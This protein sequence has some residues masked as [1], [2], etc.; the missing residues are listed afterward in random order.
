M[1]VAAALAAA[2]VTNCG[3]HSGLPFLPA[4]P[5]APRT[6]HK[7]DVTTAYHDAVLAS[8]PIAYYRLDDTGSSA[9][10]I[11]PNHLNGAVG[12]SVVKS[13]AGLVPTAPDTAMSFPGLKTAAGSVIVPPNPL[14]QVQ[15]QL[16]VECF[17][18]FTTVPALW[19]VPVSYGNDNNYSPYALYF[20]TNGTLNAQF[21]LTSGVLI[22]TDPTPLQPNT[23]YYI[24]ATYD[25]TTGRLYVNGTQVGTATK[26]GA[27]TNY[28]NKYGLGIGD[29]SSFSDPGFAGTLDEVAIYGKTLSAADVTAHYNAAQTGTGP[30]PTPSPSP[31]PTP[32]ATP[33]PSP[34]PPSTSAYSNAVLNSGPVAYYRLDD[35]GPAV[36]DSSS[37]HLNG[38]AG[39]N[40][41]KNAAGLIAT[42]SDAAMSFPG[43]RT[44]ANI[45]SVAPNSLFQAPQVTIETFLK[46]NSTP[47]AYTVPVAYGSD[48]GYA[49]Y[50]LYFGF[51]GVINAQ[52]F[53]TSGVLVVP[54]P[55]GLQ[56]NTPY[57]VVSTFDGA[58]GKLYINGA[59]VASVAKAGAVTGFDN[60]YGLGIGDDTSS[61]DPGF[62][63][64]IDEVAIY[65]R[66]LTAADV[67]SHY[68][69]AQT[70]VGPTPTP[71]PTTG[72]V[73]WPTFGYDLART[74]YNPNET[75]IGTGNVGSLQ[76]LW[77]TNLSSSGIVG[78]PV[79]A[80]NVT[81]AGTS[82]NL[83]Y[84]GTLSG[85][86]AAL[87]ADT[88]AIVWQKS[89]GVA[90]Y[91]CGAS[92]PFGVGGTAT[93]DRSQ[94]RVFVADGN[95][96]LHALDLATGAEAAGW[97]VA[98]PQSPLDSTHNFVYAGLT[99]NAAT[100]TIYVGTSST[101][102]ISP[103]YGQIDALDSH[104]GGHLGTFFPAQGQSG[105]GIWGYG[106]ASIDTAT[107]TVYIATGNADNINFPIP[108]NYGYSEDI[109]A[110]TPALGLV[111]A[112]YP[113]LPAS[114]DADF[115][116]TPLL[117]PGG[118]LAAMNKSGVL[119]L[120][121]R[122]SI[123]SGPTQSLAMS[124]PSDN[125]NFIGVPAYSPTSNLVYV[126]VPGD[127]PDG[128][129]KHGLAAFSSQGGCTLSLLW[130]PV[131]GQNSA[132]NTTTDLPHSAPS[133][134]NGVVY[135][136]DGPGKTVYAFDAVS[137]A[138]L[139]NSGT[140]V[141][142]AAYAQPM[143]DKYLYVVGFQGIVYAFSPNGVAAAAR[144]PL[145]P[146]IRPRR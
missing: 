48:R 80:S 64:T 135:D 4:V 121:N 26:T 129:Y 139:W 50:D 52:F 47:P 113:G 51:N 73:D 27:L 10:D 88:G 70:G 2:S 34:T 92:L 53:L 55:S 137:G 49:P 41:I 141:A 71:P 16:S 67:S 45:V 19:T 21:F 118:C 109:V 104:S 115:G 46:F 120:Y 98:I 65:N 112:N 74:G 146:A 72:Y 107:N 31:S 111:A 96:Q 143:I 22:V 13:V 44:A 95:L 99:F 1:F 54:S 102:D 7:L 91:F 128:T 23:A 60:T 117:Y 134:A 42:S 35:A 11:G 12:A 124:P 110:L 59:L 6:V 40:V 63:G 9:L 37:D 116:A 78:Q 136:T 33:T 90:T 101:C 89:V 24:V 3:H 57:Y 140:T 97:P 36:L 5:S 69:A 119:V 131:F 114:P 85:V 15:S 84:V 77:S 68:S 144:R 32:T 29:D 142:S 130:N 93:I 17:L 105:G 145:P 94:S 138:A 43:L 20:Y 56:P 127:S 82:R 87:D 61:E 106:G 75:T 25:G 132:V 39:A 8:G 83:M 100:S 30:T 103:W 18:K 86:F 76:L 125:G 38:V 108:Q 79:L 123:G 58:T 126:P 28:D 62:A 81:V 133:V 122:N 14:F 66:A